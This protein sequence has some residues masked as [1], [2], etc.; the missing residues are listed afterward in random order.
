MHHPAL[1]FAS[2]WAM[3]PLPAACTVPPDLLRA[4]REGVLADLLRSS[5]AHETVADGIR[6]H[7][8]A[9]SDTLSTL[10][11]VVDAERQCCRFLRFSITVEPDGGPITFELTG[12]Q[13]TR[14]F[15]EELLG[16]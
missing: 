3:E 15:L 14:E 13:G 10:A 1:L 4:R 16:T 11:R 7:F 5:A 12:P 9:R 8:P 6:F 2:Q